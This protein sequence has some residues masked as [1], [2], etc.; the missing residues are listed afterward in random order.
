MINMTAAVE[1]DEGLK[2]NLI[3]DG[4]G[5]VELLGR[6]HLL[7]GLVEGVDVG[8][9]VFGVVELHDLA[10]DGRFEGG[11]VIWQGQQSVN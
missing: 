7:G 3:G 8:I 5:G 6:H 4:F 9:V 11:V 1:L 2:G 10:G